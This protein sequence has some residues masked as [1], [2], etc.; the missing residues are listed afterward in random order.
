MTGHRSPLPS[1]LRR[2]LFERRRTH[3]HVCLITMKYK[4][5][6]LD[7]TTNTF[8]IWWVV[9]E[10]KQKE[11]YGY[12]FIFG[13]S[14]F[15]RRNH[16]F[17]IRFFLSFG[18]KFNKDSDCIHLLSYIDIMYFKEN[19]FFC[20]VTVFIVRLRISSLSSSDLV[21]EWLLSLRRLRQKVDRPTISL[22]SGVENFLFIL[23][24]L[25]LYIKL[26]GSNSPFRCYLSFFHCP[27][28]DEDNEVEYLINKL[29]FTDINVIYT[30]ELLQRKEVIIEIRLEYL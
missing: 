5:F 16:N 19:F 1:F 7:F 6:L 15:K 9:L 26:L 20:L 30:R 24:F 13:V 2:E 4:T 29:S 28:F 23:L 12:K 17:W 27:F 18:T 22:L 3:C 10:D 11:P 21:N 25:I 8:K 14:L